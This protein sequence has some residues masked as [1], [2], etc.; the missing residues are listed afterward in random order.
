MV[1]KTFRIGEKEVISAVEEYIKKHLD[2]EG[3]TFTIHSIDLV[4]T[5]DK[6]KDAG[7]DIS[8]YAEITTDDR[9]NEILRVNRDRRGR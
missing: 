5:K 6:S 2:K 8:A 7:V 3:L 4:S 9:I 1:T